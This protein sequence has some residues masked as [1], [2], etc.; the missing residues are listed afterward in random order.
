MTAQTLP[1]LLGV[2]VDTIAQPFTAST[3]Q[4]SQVQPVKPS[5]PGEPGGNGAYLVGPESYGT[6]M[7]IAGLQKAGATTFRASAEFTAGGRTFAPGTLIVEPT[8]AARTALQNVSQKTG[9]PVFSVGQAPQV[10]AEKLKDNTRIGLFRGINNMPGGWMMWL[11]EQYGV[12]FSEVVAADFAGDLN[13]KYDTIVLPAGISRTD[14]VNG[15]NRDR[16]PADWAWAY[17]VGKTGWTQL[18]DFVDGRRHAAGI[19][20]RWPR[21]AAFLLPITSA[22]PSD[23]LQDF[24]CPGSLLSQEFDT[25]DPAAW[26]MRADNPV[27]F[28][29][30]DQAYKLTGGRPVVP[31]T[32][33]A[34][35][36]C[37][38]AG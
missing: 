25:N 36:S 16:Y 1:M 2:Q 38:A 32:P 22:L 37:R 28:G 6:A 35:T 29:E 19:G 34:A 13:A 20:D 24:Y 26:G 4:V 17:G 10:A 15:L 30:D 9:I 8:A 5:F 14:I 27:W 21:P 18:H 7:M 31:S 23:E 3:N 33:A 12:D 11:F